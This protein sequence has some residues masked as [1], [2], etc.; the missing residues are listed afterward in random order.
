MGGRQGIVSL[1]GCFLCLNVPVSE[2]ISFQFP[3]N[4]VQL[5]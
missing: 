5:Q 2:L 1:S 3:A 4:Y